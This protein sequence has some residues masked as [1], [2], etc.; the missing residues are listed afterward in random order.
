M[1]LE[2]E[3]QESEQSKEQSAV[4]E[5]PPQEESSPES[6][7]SAEA[8][9]VGLAIDKIRKEI[10]KVVVGQ[11]EI[12]DLMI[13]A[14][15]TDG[16]VLLEGVPGV[17]KTLVSKLLAKCISV[18]FTRIQFTPDL[19]PTDIIGTTVF[20]MKRSEFH[21]KR[22]P[23]FSNVILIDEINRA[24][25][26]TQAALMEVMEEKQVSVDGQTY[27]LAPPFFVV[28]TQN[29][30]EQEGT[31]KLPEAQLDRFIFKLVATYPSLEEEE[32][33]LRRFKSDFYGNRE[34]QIDA[35]LSGEDLLKFRK[36][37]EQV[38][39]KD[40]LISY[41]AQIVDRTR[42]N[43]DLYLGA[44]PRASLGILKASK[45]LALMNGRGFVTPDDIKKS[46]F[47]VLNHRLILSYERE[48]EG[49]ELKEVIESL[50][51]K[52]DVPK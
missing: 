23:I 38:F 37:V 45:A 17:A 26:K 30:V 52:V 14:L 27:A 10:E 39:I 36:V 43:S 24:P 4:P 12:I 6:Q 42:N 8:Y 29:P 48:I 31:Y 18:D 47:P 40:E 28:A 35:V 16:H 3:S 1:S 11:V 7:L 44:S 46:V 5:T 22:G 2:N 21:Y 9:E 41:I 33:M 15:L 19:M 32:V 49:V 51:R 13:A 34:E 20:D 50:I 25:A